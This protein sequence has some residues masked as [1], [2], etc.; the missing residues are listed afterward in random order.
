M[1]KRVSTGIEGLDKMLKGGLVKGRTYLVKGGPGSGK[2]TLAIQY[3]IE[4]ARRGERTVYITLE[5]PIE[6]IKENM[7]SFGFDLSD[8]KMIDFSP[9]GDKS[10]FNNLLM[11]LEMDTPSLQAVLESEFMSINPTRVVIDSVTMLKVAS[12]SEFDYRKD[13]L[14]L[15]D[16]L[17]KHKVTSILTSEI[18]ENSIEDYLVSGVIELHTIDMS[19][20]FLRGVRVVKIRGSGFDETIRP[21]RITSKGL[22]VYSD[23]K[24]FE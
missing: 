1:P 5:E 12:K 11:G 17:R 19:G 23:L 20:K 13:F 3:L 2:T 22:E 24:L 8:I 4:G 10:I 15:V 21:Y 6:E 7:E 16:M 14:L 9:S 18:T